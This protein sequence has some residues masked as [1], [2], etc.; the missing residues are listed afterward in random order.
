MTCVKN[1]E[2]K[3]FWQ[4]EPGNYIIPNICQVVSILKVLSFEED[5]Q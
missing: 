3:N 5:C 4:V 2:G 1:I